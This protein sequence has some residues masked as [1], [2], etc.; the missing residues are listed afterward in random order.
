MKNLSTT[1]QIHANI[2]QNQERAHAMTN[3][4]HMDAIRKSHHAML[5][6]HPHLKRILGELL[7]TA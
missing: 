6:N 2:K 4:K 1:A 7:K 3:Q 5:D